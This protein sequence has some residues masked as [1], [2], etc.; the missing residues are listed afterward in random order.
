MKR[1]E[2]EDIPQERD[3]HLDIPAEANRDKHIN[4]L[5]AEETSSS[6]DAPDSD[7]PFYVP[8]NTPL[9]D[10]GPLDGNRA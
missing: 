10:R 7:S 3:R 9:K 1:R 8:N 6:D 5:E 2:Q 4:F